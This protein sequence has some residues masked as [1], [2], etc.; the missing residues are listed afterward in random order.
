M[1]GF[2]PITEDEDFWAMTDNPHK[3]ILR[4]FRGHKNL[5]P[6][7]LLYFSLFFLTPARSQIES[8]G[9]VGTV[10]VIRR[11]DNKII[12]AADSRAAGGTRNEKNND[13][14]I[15][16]LDNN[17]FV[18]SAGIR[19]FNVEQDR[20]RIKLTWDSHDIAFESFAS[21][22]SKSVPRLAEDW[23]TNGV[24]LLNQF[25]ADE[26]KQLAD[27]TDFTAEG[28]KLLVAGLNQQG[29]IDAK[30][31][32]VT[33]KRNEFVFQ[34]IDVPF[35]F[36]VGIARGHE[37]VDEFVSQS[38]ER[39]KR[40]FSNWKMTVVGKTQDQIDQLW[41]KQLVRWVIF[42]DNTGKVGGDTQEVEL[43]S[44][45]TVSWL[46]YGPCKDQQTKKGIET[47]FR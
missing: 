25:P 20:P 37:I 22:S 13:C 34:I 3:R 36:P 19:N 29:S 1:A 6:I 5:V 10:V 44:K 46:E 45:G 28:S 24:R 42:Y 18:A 16:A 30:I 21:L 32:I 38:T 35:N 12:V 15:L 41:I 26:R 33:F 47:P 40:E 17:L 39:S 4:R 11:T 7:S 2:D 27:Q 31:A 23:A 9:T 8:S 43:R 14:K